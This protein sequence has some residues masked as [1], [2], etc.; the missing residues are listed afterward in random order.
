VVESH[1]QDSSSAPDGGMRFAIHEYL[2]EARIGPDG[3]V[4]KLEAVPGT[5]P[6]ASC[7]VA[8]MN[9]EVLIGTHARELRD[10]VLERMK[11]TGGCTHLNDM[12]RSLAETEV[13]AAALPG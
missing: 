9:N 4:R 5:L 8:P 1:F 12:L 2:L 7:R 10:V 13:L 3:I 11:F 6:Y